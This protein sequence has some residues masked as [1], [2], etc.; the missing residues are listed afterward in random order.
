MYHIRL[1]TPDD[2]E[3]LLRIYSYYVENTCISY[4][5]ESPTVEEFRHRIE[6]VL[7][8]YPYLVAELDSQQPKANSQQPQIVGVQPTTIVSRHLSIL[9]RTPTVAA[10][11]PPS[12]RNWKNVLELRA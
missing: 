2:A 11:A 7:K 1:A 9:T 5:L 8:H 4:E 6:E 3:A 12:M 10:S